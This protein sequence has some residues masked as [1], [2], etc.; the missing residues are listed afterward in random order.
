V[1]RRDLLSQK[2]NSPNCWAP[3]FRG[4]KFVAE[5]PPLGAIRDGVGEQLSKLNP[6]IKRF[7]NPREYP[8]GFDAG[9]HDLKT[10]LLL[11]AKG[12]I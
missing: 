2:H 8:A 10:Q 12:E 6:A 3:I 9:L 11:R 4:V 5:A 1:T 7:G